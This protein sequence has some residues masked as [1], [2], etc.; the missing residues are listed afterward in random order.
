M[1]QS[2][3]MACLV[4]SQDEKRASYTLKHEP[5]FGSPVKMMYHLSS[6][7]WSSG[8]LLNINLVVMQANNK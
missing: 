3:V 8:A 4:T 6:M 2:R 7:V 1:H 5:L